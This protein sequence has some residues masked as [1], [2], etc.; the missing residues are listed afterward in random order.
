M[1]ILIADDNDHVRRAIRALLSREAG[2]EICGEASDGP[3]TMDRVRELRPHVVLLDISMP[4]TDGF[5]TARRI[6]D[7]FPEIKIV[8]VSQN[9]PERLSPTALKAGAVACLDKSCL[10]AELLPAL[11][12]YA[13]PTARAQAAR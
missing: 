5:E 13:G 3:Q 7:E 10:G 4:D 9:D 6:R 1:R 11:K 2:L 8:I 12:K